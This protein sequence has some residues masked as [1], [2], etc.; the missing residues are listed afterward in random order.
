MVGSLLT[1][2]VLDDLEIK[3]RRESSTEAI[4]LERSSSFMELFEKEKV[5]N[6]ALHFLWWSL[7]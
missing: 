2:K 1:A 5:P 7:P 4:I 3:S 6:R